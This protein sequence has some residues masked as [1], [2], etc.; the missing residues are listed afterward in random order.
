MKRFRT[1]SR[2]SKAAALAMTLILLAF[3]LMMSG[4]GEDIATKSSAGDTGSAVAWEYVAPSDLSGD[5]G[6]VDADA[7][8]DAPADDNAKTIVVPVVS[9]KPEAATAPVAPAAPAEPEV[10][11]APAAPA[12]AA[13][14]PALVS[15]M[16]KSRPAEEKPDE[17][18]DFFRSAD[19]MDL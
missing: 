4:C 5:A 16:R 10:P 9:A 12:P 19:N 2:I 3:T 13:E 17:G 18:S 15:T 1:Y 6:E 7:K 8:A 14:T 11:A